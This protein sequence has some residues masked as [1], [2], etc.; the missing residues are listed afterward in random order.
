MRQ[1]QRSAMFGIAN[2]TLDVCRT[3]NG[4]IYS[5]L[6]NMALDGLKQY[7]NLFHPCPF[8]VELI[9]KR[10]IIL[11]Y[12]TKKLKELFASLGSFIFKRLLDRC[13]EIAKCYNTVGCLL[14]RVHSHEAKWPN[15]NSYFSYANFF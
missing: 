1:S 4:M 13:V 2:I 10:K 3:M 14:Q 8:V 15:G 5:V 7:S 9:K 11:N 12:R 6:L